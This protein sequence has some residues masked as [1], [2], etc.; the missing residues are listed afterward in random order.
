MEVV[1]ARDAVADVD[2]AVDPVEGEALGEHVAKIEDQAPAQRLQVDD[3]DQ[4]RDAGVALQELP[5]SERQR[6]LAAEGTRVEPHRRAVPVHLP[7]QPAR[8][9]AQHV[10]EIEEIEQPAGVGHRQVEAH[11]AQRLR[12]AAAS[13]PGAGGVEGGSVVAQ[14]QVFQPPQLRIP[15]FVV[16]R[17]QL[18]RA[19]RARAEHQLVGD[20]VERGQRARRRIEQLLDVVDAIVGDRQPREA[21]RQ[22]P[23]RGARFGG[24]PPQ[25]AIDA[26]RMQVRAPGG[27]DARGADDHFLESAP[28]QAHA[29]GDDRDG[30]GHERRRTGGGR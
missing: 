28:A 1:G 25:V 3:A 6:D 26:L 18:Q 11:R 23:C 27:I 10:A 9:A 2:G 21:R 16:P 30:V 8:A 13:A 24:A 29:I 12:V 17:A 7:A 4:L 5:L 15:G 19:E 20:D 22:P 14:L